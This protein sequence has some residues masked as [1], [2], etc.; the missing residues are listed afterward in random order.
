MQ[1]AVVNSVDDT[2]TRSGSDRPHKQ[3]LRRPIESC[4]LGPEHGV[5]FEET[6]SDTDDN[7]DADRDEKRMSDVPHY[8][9]WD[10]GKEATCSEKD[11]GSVTETS[12]WPG[13]EENDHQRTDEI[14]NPHC[15]CR[16][17]CSG[18][19][20]LFEFQF[21]VHHKLRLCLSDHASFVNN[22]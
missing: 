6:K 15:G 17:P 12:L 19:I 16:N 22:L 8:E 13:E 20:R 14:G 1:T 4:T 11:V 21:K 7:S 9:V 5:V 10:H 3:C 2:I 18:S